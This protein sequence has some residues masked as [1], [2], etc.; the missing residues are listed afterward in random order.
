MVN[1]LQFMDN[2]TE[3]VNVYSDVHFFCLHILVTT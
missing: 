3:T 2:K 1:A